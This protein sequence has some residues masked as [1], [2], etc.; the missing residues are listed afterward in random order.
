MAKEG[1]KEYLLLPFLVD[2]GEISPF[3]CLMLLLHLG[4]GK[5]GFF[6][7]ILSTLFEETFLLK[8]LSIVGLGVHSFP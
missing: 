2:V 8:E 4:Q 7:D 3:S 6:I 5:L 1:P